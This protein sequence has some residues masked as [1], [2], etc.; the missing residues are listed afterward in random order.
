MSKKVFVDSDVVISSLLSQKGAAN[1]LLNKQRDK[2]SISNISQ[3]ELKKVVDRLGISQ[4]K[5]QTLI[6]KRLKVVKLRENKTKIKSNFQAYSTDPNDAH[7]VAGAK[8]AKA[9]FLLTYNLKHFQRQ[10]IYDDLGIV[11]LTPAQYLQYL[12]SLG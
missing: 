11:V 10:K 12:R 9:K 2:F 8:A 3:K 4:D 5:L 1:L 6:R 7:I